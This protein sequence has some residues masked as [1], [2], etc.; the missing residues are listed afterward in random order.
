MKKLLCLIF[1][2][3][4][5]G[6]FQP[7]FAK[8][9]VSPKELIIMIYQ[10]LKTY[11]ENSPHHAKDREKINSYF[12]IDAMSHDAI[13]DHWSTMTSSQ[14]RTYNK[15]MHDLLLKTVYEDTSKKLQKGSFI[16]KTARP[17][18]SQRYRV[19]TDILVKENNLKV[20]NDYTIIKVKGRWRVR[21]IFIDN[22]NLALD[23]RNQ[24]NTI[25][26]DYGI[27][28][29]SQSLFSRIRE[30]LKKTQDWTDF[31]QNRKKEEN[32]ISSKKRP[33]LLEG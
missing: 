16:I 11:D 17:I 4:F 28:K 23:Y 26:K 14:K 10:L 29:G 30:S 2:F 27:D 13:Q 15:L 20:A 12:L 21:E 5:L 1:I 24:F 32:A 33:T 22:A 3:P 19:L 7:S 18:S 31:D 25:I 8:E 9:P 6:I